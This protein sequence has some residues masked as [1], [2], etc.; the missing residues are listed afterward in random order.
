MLNL[1][2]TICNVHVL[3]LKNTQHYYAISLIRGFTAFLSGR[4]R[5]KIWR[6]CVTASNSASI[7]KYMRPGRAGTGPDQVTQKIAQ[8]CISCDIKNIMFIVNDFSL[9]FSLQVDFKFWILPRTMP[10][11]EYRVANRQWRVPKQVQRCRL[12]YHLI[13]HDIAWGG[14]CDFFGQGHG[15]YEHSSISERMRKKIHIS[16]SRCLI[17]GHEKP[18]KSSSKLFFFSALVKENTTRSIFGLYSPPKTKLSCMN[19][20]VQANIGVRSHRLCD[21]ASRLSFHCVL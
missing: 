6:Y 16:R 8:I 2:L 19:E 3:H 12:L 21:R 10:C 15:K 20:R 9:I 14:L 4:V 1:Q 11:K 17:T 5:A 18:P 7:I 13:S